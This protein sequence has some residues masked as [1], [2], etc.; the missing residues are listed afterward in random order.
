MME[1]VQN[2]RDSYE[3][4]GGPWPGRLAILARP[5]GAEWLE[6]E[7][8]NWQRLGIDVVVSLLTPDE[9]AEFELWNEETCCRSNGIEF[10][11]LAIPD[12]DVP[13]S[14]KE[15][16][17]QV[18]RLD[19]EMADGKAVGIHCRQGIGRSGLLSACLLVSSGLSPEAAF[20]R[21]TE[22]RGCPVPETSEQCQWV[23][24]FAPELAA[25]GSR[26]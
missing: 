24:E 5:R 14:R 17:K 26:H 13:R 4:V 9:I 1:R 22:A 7:V 18:T 23:E 15:V 25:V 6:Y 21:L 19:G 16:L 20:K 8:R 10:V 2:M 3:V 12:R 11:L